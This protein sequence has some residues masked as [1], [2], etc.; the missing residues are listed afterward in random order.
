MSVCAVCS[1]CVCVC[2]CVCMC[3]TMCLSGKKTKN[4]KIIETLIRLL[5]NFLNSIMKDT[6]IG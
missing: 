1:V 3:V 4:I 2:V 5:F 6:E